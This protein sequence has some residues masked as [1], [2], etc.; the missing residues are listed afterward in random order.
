MLLRDLMPRCARGKQIHKPAC[1]APL[2]ERVDGCTRVNTHSCHMRLGAH[3]HARA[4]ASVGALVSYGVCVSVRAQSKG[5][6]SFQ[7]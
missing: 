3:I 1:T 5:L 4:A 2:R 6:R 7:T